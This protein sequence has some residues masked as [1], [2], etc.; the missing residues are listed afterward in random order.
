MA[1]TDEPK[2]I[3]FTPEETKGSTKK[4]IVTNKEYG[5]VL[6][7]IKWYPAWRKYAFFPASNCVFEADCLKDI[8]VKLNQMMLVYKA[9]KQSKKQGQL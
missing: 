3:V 8:T 6:G 1:L 9:D 5:T 4:Y 7:V 2:W